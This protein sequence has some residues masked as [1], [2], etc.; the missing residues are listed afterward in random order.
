M[1]LLLFP[2]I[3]S[4]IKCEHVFLGNFR[5]LIML[6]KPISSRLGSYEGGTEKILTRQYIYQCYLKY[7]GQKKDRDGKRPMIKREKRE[8]VVWVRPISMSSKE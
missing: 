6:Y 5:K 2:L 7:A 3:H 8:V 1:G 4:F